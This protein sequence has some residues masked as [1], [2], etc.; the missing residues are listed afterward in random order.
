MSETFPEIIS[1]LVDHELDEHGCRRADFPAPPPKI[2]ARRENG[3]G[4]SR[5]RGYR[6]D[7]RPQHRTRALLYSV[8]LILDEYEEHLELEIYAEK[9]DRVELLRALPA[10]GEA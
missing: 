6:T 7:W 8:Q 4:R 1:R 10:E 3:T 2:T 5:A 9:K